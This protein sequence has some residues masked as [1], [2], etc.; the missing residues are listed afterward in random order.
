M[1]IFGISPEKMKETSSVFTL[2]EIH[3]QPSTWKK[4][5]AQL[6]ACKEELQAFLDQVLGAE[7]FDIVLTGA[8]TSE[9]IGNS[10][11]YVLSYDSGKLRTFR[12]L[13]GVHRSRGGGRGCMPE[14]LSSFCN[15]QP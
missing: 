5:C 2:T 8:G 9:F 4:T 7:D 14:P 3:Q 11:E 1:S 6:A 10:L 13:T 12:K 15:L